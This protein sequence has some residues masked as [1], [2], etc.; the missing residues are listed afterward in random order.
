MLPVQRRNLVVQR[1][2]QAPRRG[3]VARGSGSG[4]LRKQGSNIAKHAR[5]RRTDRRPLAC[6]EQ[7]VRQRVDQAVRQEGVALR[8][9][10]EKVSTR[11]STDKAETWFEAIFFSSS[12]T[13]FVARML[14]ID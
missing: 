4:P 11:V 6:C 13:L 9:D 2:G 3:L 7:L 14:L 1:L 8:K 10:R 12:L 5:H